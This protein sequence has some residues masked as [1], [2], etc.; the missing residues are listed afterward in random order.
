MYLNP[1]YYVVQVGGR[2]PQPILLRRT[3]GWV[4]TSTHPHGAYTVLCGRGPV[5]EGVLAEGRAKGMV[6][7]GTAVA[8]TRLVRRWM[9]LGWGEEEVD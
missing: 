8:W 6:E 3:G 1:S 7:R 9:A 4:C 2:V 5:R